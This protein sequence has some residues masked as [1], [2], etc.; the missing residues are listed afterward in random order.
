MRSLRFNLEEIESATQYFAPRNLLGKSVFSAI[1][2]GMLRDGTIVA[3]KSIIKSSCK[4]EE[5]EFV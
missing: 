4:S 5:S 1:H 2:K 3:I